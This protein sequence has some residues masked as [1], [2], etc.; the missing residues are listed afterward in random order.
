MTQFWPMRK[1]QKYTGKKKAYG[2]AFTFLI[3]E[4]DMTGVTACLLLSAFNVDIILRGG[5][6]I[7]RL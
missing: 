6:D 5:A 4:G 7:L 2:K 3:N 1:K